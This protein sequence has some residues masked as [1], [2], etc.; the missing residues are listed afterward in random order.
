MDYK[1][2]ISDY[3]SKEIGKY[4]SFMRHLKK[5]IVEKQSKIEMFIK[6]IQDNI[7]NMD[8]FNKP[9]YS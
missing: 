3:I 5:K 4:Q 2:Q 9:K 7:N 8:N 1:T 6:D